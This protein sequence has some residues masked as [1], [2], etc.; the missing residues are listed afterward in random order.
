MLMRRL[1]HT[2]CTSRLQMIMPASFSVKILQRCIPDL[3]FG[4]KKPD[5][6][7]SLGNKHGP[8][9]LQGNLL[10]FDGML[11]EQWMTWFLPG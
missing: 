9:D 2:G 5:L 1:F 6:M 3:L 11:E 8:S 10:L 4:H 7:A